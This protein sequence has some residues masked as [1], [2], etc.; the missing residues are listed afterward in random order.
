M[1]AKSCGNPVTPA[2]RIHHLQ[3]F[4]IPARGWISTL[5]C[6]SLLA[7][8]RTEKLDLSRLKLPPG[9][10][11]ELFGKAP[12]ARQMAFSPGGVLLVTETSDGIVL[13]LP[14]HD[15]TGHADRAVPVLS[16]LN[17]PHG[18]AFHNGKLYIAEINA[19]RRYDW[20]EARLRASNSQKIVDLPGSGGGHSTRTLL[21]ANRKMYVAVGSSCNVCVEDDQRR[22]AVTESNDDGSGQRTF[23]SGLRNAVGLAVNSKT[24]TIWATDNGRDWLGDDLPPEEVNDL[25]TNG[26]NAGWPYC[27]GNR[28]PDRSQ[29]KTYDCSK[30][31]APA[32]EMQ[33]HSAPLG[34]LFYNGEMFPAEYRGNLFVT[35]HGSWN[36][37]IPTGYKILRI[38]INDKG[39]T[40]GPPEDFISGWIRP[41]E[42]NKGVWMGR[43]VALSV[44]T[45]GA[46]YVSD[47]SAGVVYRV[48]WGK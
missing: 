45:D 31:I 34:L 48:T 32:V 2:G 8:T 30:T 24:N 11:I 21:F 15:H 17:A 29:S 14:D 41:G 25:G 33:A 38:K 13:A 18:L 44:G 3:G 9:F 16:G 47:D 37:S 12:H 28:I 39:E 40:Q 27:Y 23:A 4:R 7:C 10:Q 42:T 20:E 46:L 43:P 35:F 1:A 22:A 6:L 36:R 26:G 19:V 5:F